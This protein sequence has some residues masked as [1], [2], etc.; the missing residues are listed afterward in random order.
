[1]KTIEL[2]FPKGRVVCFFCQKPLMQKDKFS[3]LHLETSAGVLI[4]ACGEHKDHGF[5]LVGSLNQFK[6]SRTLA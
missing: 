2:P 4:I 5:I 1:M 6:A 3:D